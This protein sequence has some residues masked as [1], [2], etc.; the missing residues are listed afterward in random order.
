MT[1][2]L[3]CSAAVIITIAPG[4]GKMTSFDYR[5][6]ESAKG[7]CKVHFPNSPCLKR[8]HKVR[9]HQYQATCGR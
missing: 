7:R 1:L 2:L 8:F 6:L 3:N 4:V 9:Y 5:S